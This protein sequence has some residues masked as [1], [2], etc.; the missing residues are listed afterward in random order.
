VDYDTKLG[1]W[2]KQVEEAKRKAE[3][4]RSR[5]SGS[6]ADDQTPVLVQAPDPTPP[7]AEAPARVDE[8]EVQVA[9][10]V[11]EVER[12]ESTGGVATVE[13]VGE[14]VE[15]PREPAQPAVSLPGLFEETEASPVEDFLSFLS[16]TEDKKRETVEEPVDVDVPSVGALHSLSEGTGEPRPIITPRVEAE[17]AEIVVQAQAPVKA[18][19][20]PP[21]APVATA[22]PSP[23]AA[24]ERAAVPSPVQATEETMEE[25]QNFARFPQ[26]LHDLLQSAQDE[27]A[28]NSY[29]AFKESR[30]TLIERLLDP[31]LTLEEAARIL[32]VCP[33][34][35][36]RY[37]NR[38]VL[39]HFR[40]AGN[41]RRFRL[42][43]VLAFMESQFGGVKPDAGEIQ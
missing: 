27:V 40:T 4:L 23:A 42:S 2:F 8:P 28:Q 30:A 12:R 6:A 31:P 13:M 15:A 24:V 14:P 37:T 18:P 34:T 26:Q 3:E 19:A 9:E 22:P 41:Q 7:R 29:K 10:E 20:Q 35:V 17:P 21:A 5:K 43:E 33:T 38:G 36:R 1:E 11:Q 32:N 39:T 25:P 16:R